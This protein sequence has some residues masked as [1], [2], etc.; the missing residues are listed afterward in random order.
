MK[1]LNLLR[2]LPK[3]KR[4]IKIRKLKKN[5]E[6]LKQ[7]K[8]FGKLYFDG[9]RKFGYGGYYDDGR[10]NNVARDIIKHYKLK[11]GSKILDIG[12]A[13]GYLVKELHNMGMNAFGIDISKY[14]IS[15]SPKIIKKKLQVSNLLSIPFKNNTFDLVLCINTLHNLNKINCEKGIVELLRV[16]KNK[17]FIQVDSYYNLEQEKLFL[18]WVLTAQYHDYPNEWRKLFKKTG[19]NYDYNWTILK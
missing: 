19:Y 14:A 1:K 18:D 4:N 2:S 10:W 11:K 17:F 6:I 13:K 8:K 15:K 16:G 7:A 9:D 12:C 5:K 3:S